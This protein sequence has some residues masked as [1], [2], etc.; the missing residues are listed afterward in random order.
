MK[1]EISSCV[2]RGSIRLSVTG[3]L[4][5]R[6]TLSGLL[7]QGKDALRQQDP[8]EAILAAKQVPLPFHLKGIAAP[9]CS[10]PTGHVLPSK[11]EIMPETSRQDGIVPEGTLIIGARTRRP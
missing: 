8:D 7:K 2:L 1:H 10:P 9:A 4:Q 6:R 3:G 11:A 5:A